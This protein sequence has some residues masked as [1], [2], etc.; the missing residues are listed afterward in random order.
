VNRLGKEFA[1]IIKLSQV[2][3][4]SLLLASVLHDI[5][6]IAIPD[7]VLRKPGRLTRDEY[8]LIR[9]HPQIGAMLIEHVPGFTDAATAVLNHH[10]RFDGRGY[11]SKK[12]GTDIPLLARVVTLIDAFSAMVMD[13]PYHKGMDEAT[14][15]TELR[16]GS[17]TQFDPELVEK[18]AQMIQASHS[19]AP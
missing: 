1:E 16:K 13:R 17:G 7:Q 10:E 9:R 15:L 8:D 5:G 3:T 12:A 19:K 18:F 4:Q 2:D 6:K 11:P 14:A